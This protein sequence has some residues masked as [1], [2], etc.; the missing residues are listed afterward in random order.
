MSSILRVLGRAI[1]DSRG[2]PTVEVEV[3]TALEVQDVAPQY[4]VEP[5]HQLDFL[6]QGE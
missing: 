1:L 6:P 2:N 5:A 3:H 4:Q